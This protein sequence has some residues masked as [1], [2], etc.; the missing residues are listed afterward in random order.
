MTTAPS[1]ARPTSS[2]SLPTAGR[3]SPSSLAGDGEAGDS[4]GCGVAVSGTT[5]FAGASHD[6]DHGASSGSVYVLNVGG[7]LSEDTGVS[8]RDQLTTDTTP[9]LTLVFGEPVYGDDGDVSVLDPNGDPVTPGPVVSWGGTVLNITL[10]TPL[11]VDGEYTVTLRGASTIIDAAGNVIDNDG[12]DQTMSFTL[13]TIEPT[14][15]AVLVRGTAWTDGFLDYLDAEGLAHPG[16]ARLGYRVPTGSAQLDVLPWGNVDQ[17]TIVFDENVVIGRDDLALSGIDAAE[18][19]VAAFSYDPAAYAATWTLAERLD[20]DMISITLSG[21]VEDLAGNGLEGG[22]FAL[23]TNV[24]PGDAD[25]SGMVDDADAAIMAAHWS[26]SGVTLYGDF[27]GDGLVDDRD[28][29]ILAAHWRTE[30]QP[31]VPG[32]ANRDGTVDD[33]DASILGAHWQQQSGAV[34]ADGRFQRRRQGRRQGRCNPGRPLG[35]ASV[36]SDRAARV[37][38]ATR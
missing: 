20:A 31:L 11:T 14:V 4:F 32:D 30:S 37:V 25:H 5:A 35:T 33:R 13:D 9:A 36:G 3:K 27:N 23:S 18:H 19:S 24:L 34:W 10:S 1:R 21:T 26:S 15:E 29:S 28:A 2:R 17:I 12:L 22:E 38:A 8:C 7:V 16:V 6:D